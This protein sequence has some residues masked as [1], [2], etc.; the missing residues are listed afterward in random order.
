MTYVARVGVRTAIWVLLWGDVS[1]ANVAEIL[2]VFKRTSARCLTSGQQLV[3]TLT[4]IPGNLL[5]TAKQH[6]CA[7]PI[8]SNLGPRK[9]FWVV[10]IPTSRSQ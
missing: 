4:L 10:P 2:H 5:T 9:D 1:V 7:T 6:L 8:V 3:D